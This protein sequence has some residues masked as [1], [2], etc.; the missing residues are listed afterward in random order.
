MSASSASSS[1]SSACSR[2]PAKSCASPRPKSAASWEWTGA[3]WSNRPRRRAAPFVCP[4]GHPRVVLR[5]RRSS[6]SSGRFPPK[7]GGRWRRAPSWPSRRQPRLP[8]PAGS[9]PAGKSPRSSPLL[10]W[11]RS[12]AMSTGSPPSWSAAGPPAPGAGTNSSCSKKPWRGSAR[13]SNRRAAPAPFSSA[14]NGTASCSPA[15]RSPA[16]RSTPTTG[17][18]FS[19]MRPPNSGAGGR[20]STRSAGAARGKWPDLTAARCP[21]IAVRPRRPVRTAG[22]CAARRRS[23]SGPTAPAGGWRRIRRRS[24][25]P[26]AAAPG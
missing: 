23:S 2:S 13:S 3:A 5:R 21:S 26:T 11:R 4:T 16:T 17:S 8:R 10:R 22:P 24:L 1:A 6:S 9:R 14:K 15:C 20:S 7:S 18:T 19:T 12:T 25:T